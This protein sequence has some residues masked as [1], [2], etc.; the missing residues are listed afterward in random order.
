MFKM[1]TILVV[2]ITQSVTKVSDGG[3]SWGTW[4]LV[5]FVDYRILRFLVHISHQHT[6]KQ[7]L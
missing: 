4:D 7:M 2:V 6:S 1:A 3:Q 5:H